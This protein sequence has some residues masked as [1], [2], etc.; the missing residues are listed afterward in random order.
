MASQYLVFEPFILIESPADTV[1]AVP[2]DVD[3]ISVQAPPFF[4]YDMVLVAPE[5]IAFHK[6]EP[7]VS[8]SNVT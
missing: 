5:P 6:I 8:T 2:L 7:P 3:V 4:E 1:I